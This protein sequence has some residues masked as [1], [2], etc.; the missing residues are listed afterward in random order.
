MLGATLE[1]IRLPKNLSGFLTG[2]SSLGRRGLIIETAAGVHP[3]FSGWLTLEITNVGE[4]PIELKPGMEICQLFLHRTTK[5]VAVQSSALGCRR[6][7]AWGH[8]G[9]SAISRRL[10][11]KLVGTQE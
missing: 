7:P 8:V 6:R 11:E 5:S 1:W 10:T 9:A 3:G 2:K 4:V